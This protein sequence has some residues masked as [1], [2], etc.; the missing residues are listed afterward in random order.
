MLKFIDAYRTYKSPD[1]MI[2][3]FSFRPS[4]FQRLTGRRQKAVRF[5]G[6]SMVWYS[7]PDGVRVSGSMERTLTDVWQREINKPIVIFGPGTCS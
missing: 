1:E 7:W 4:L 5:I 6:K 2:L 3:N